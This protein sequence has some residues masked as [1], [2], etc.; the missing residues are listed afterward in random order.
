MPSSDT[1]APDAPLAITSVTLTDGPLVPGPLVPGPPGDAPLTAADLFSPAEEHFLRQYSDNLSRLSA[2]L[3]AFPQVP[4]PSMQGEAALLQKAGGLLARAEQLPWS[5]FAS[6]LGADRVFFISHLKRVCEDAETHKAIK[7]LILLA[8]VLGLL[9]DKQQNGRQ[10][11]LVFAQ[12][13]QPEEQERP[14]GL[15]FTLRSGDYRTFDS[16]KDGTK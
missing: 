8:R 12:A 11:A 9:T 6:C 1:Q 2:M 14:T 3:A 15:P 5:S 4:A 7:G 16:D 10:V 13:R